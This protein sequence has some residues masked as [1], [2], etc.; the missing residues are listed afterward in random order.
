M[1]KL[2]ALVG[3]MLSAILTGCTPETLPDDVESWVKDPDT[4]LEFN[5]DDNNSTTTST[6]SP[7]TLEDVKSSVDWTIDDGA[8]VEINNNVPFF[9]DY[10]TN[11]FEEYSDLDNLGRCGVAYANIC[12]ELQPTEKRGNIGS[13]KPSGWQTSNYNEYPGLIDGNYLYNRCHLIGYQLAGENANEKNLITGTRYL[14]IDGMLPYENMVDDYIEQNPNNHVMYRVTPM[15]NGDDLVAQGVLMEGYSVEDNGKLQF[16]VYCYN[17]QPGIMI[18]YSNGD[19]FY[20]GGET[21]VSNT[22][23]TVE[24]EEVTYILN[25][26]TKKIHMPTCGSANS[27]KEE[28]KE[29]T[30]KSIEELESE[31]YT[32]CGSCKP[33]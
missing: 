20:V 33:H 31:G 16:C 17:V 27:M 9:T 26:H 5:I 4:A 12:K 29:E 25:T 2:I 11:V 1:K 23:N 19:N 7:I 6:S 28:N 15:Y 18:D 32:C 22:D 3:I 13:V 14:N 24:N 8:Y 30:H 21:T 10:T